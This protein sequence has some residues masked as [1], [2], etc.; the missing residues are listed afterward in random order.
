M[1]ILFFDIETVPTPDALEENNLKGNQPQ[2]GEKDIIKRLS[3]SAVTARIL[4]LGYVF[5]SPRDASIE[6]LKGEEV[7]I[8][9][10]FWKLAADTS[11]FVGHNI[12]DFDLRF[13]DQRSII[14][15]IKP[16]I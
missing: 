6:I 1:K 5:D 13:I 15:R 16:C 4:C 8:L 14:N 2:L 7:N 12:L 3:L 9:E 11:L 10:K